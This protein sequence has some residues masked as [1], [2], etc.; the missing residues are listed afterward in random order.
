M[1]ARE[2]SRRLRQQGIFVRYFD[3]P[4]VKDCIRITVGKPEHS[5]RLL[6]ALREIG[7]SLAP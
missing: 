1:D 7:G 4:G 5:E 2:V 6:A 3:T